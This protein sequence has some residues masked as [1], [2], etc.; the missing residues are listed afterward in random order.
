M[1]NIINNPAPKKILFKG[2]RQDNG[3][4]V[5][6]I[7][8]DENHIGIFHDDTEEEDCWI[9]IFPVVPGTI[10]E[11]TG[12]QDA[13]R[14]DIFVGDIVEE[15]CNGLVGAVVWD[16]QLGTY[17]IEGLGEGYTIAESHISWHIIGNIH[18][19]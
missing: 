9:E 2:I 1:A 17:R 15:G 14:K 18:K 13:D 4:W 19:N 10:S 8:L 7:Y 16:N 6:G 12:K 3:Q 5:E 11:Y